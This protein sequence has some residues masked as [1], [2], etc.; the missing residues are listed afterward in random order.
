MS[1]S[2]KSGQSIV[3]TIR[4][5]LARTVFSG[6]SDRVARKA[7]LVQDI[8]SLS[9]RIILPSLPVTD[10]EIARTTH[11]NKGQEL[12][13]QEMWH[14]LSGII[15]YAD[16]ARLA[17]PGGENATMLLARGA[18][19][20]VV[21]AA[22]DALCDG[23]DPNP[24]GIAALEQMLSEFENDYAFALVVAL[25]H[26]DI[27]WAWRKLAQG[28]CQQEK[29]LRFRTHF[30]RAKDL[31]APFD[32]V[33]YDSPALAAAHCALIEAQKTPEFG[34]SDCYKSLIE[35]DPDSPRHMRALGQNLLPSR[36][37]SYVKLER[38][39]QETAEQTVEVWGAGGYC[40]T[41]LDALALDPG[42][43]CLL[44]SD[45]FI[46]GMHDILALKR[47]QS[48]PN[49]LAAFC[50]IV[51]AAPEDK[52]TLPEA[53]EANRKKLNGCL[54]WILETHLQE[55]HPLVWSQIMLTP[56]LTPSL[57]PRQA[58][59]SKGRHT[60]LQAIAERFADDIADG[61]SIT[62][63][64]SGMYRLPSL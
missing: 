9:K 21:A 31:L 27:G 22:E 41:Y 44:D 8:D 5:K 18:R 57:P 51:M 53:A 3:S 1:N 52:S 6:R 20:D 15:H 24:D 17:T 10:E 43:L 39:A 49:L 25:A 26:V 32:P 4:S 13:R 19:S 36:F 35:L 34:L 61:G 16:D 62:F 40:W 12:A 47:D 48:V 14:E 45:L 28:K 58:L 59:V 46:A 50:A 23:S 38:A 56:G 11:H 55:L 37:G 60:A 29:D 54:D 42:A 30:R 64:S 63:S 33:E 7:L 2:P